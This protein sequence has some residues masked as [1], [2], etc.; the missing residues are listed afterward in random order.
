MVSCTI[1]KGRDGTTTTYSCPNSLAL[2]NR[3]ICGVDRNDQLRGYYHVRLKCRKYYKYIFWFMFDLAI[4]NA[5]ILSQSHPDHRGNSLKDFRT[6]LAKELIGTYSGRKQTG[7]PSIGPPTKR[8]CQYHFP[9]RRTDGAYRRCHYCYHYRNL[10]YSLALQRMSVAP[11]PH[12]KTRK[13]LL[14]D[15]PH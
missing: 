7:R 1:C 3:H 8:F 11:L 12:W 10:W 5:Y 2:Y 9:L 15:L 14:P 4:T 13:C 6:T